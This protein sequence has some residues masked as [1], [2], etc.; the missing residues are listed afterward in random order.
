[1]PVDISQEL[2]R[3]DLRAIGTVFVRSG[4][5]GTVTLWATPETNPERL[6][7]AAQEGGHEPGALILVFAG[8][9]R[10]Y[11]RPEWQRADWLQRYVTELV[12]EI[13]RHGLEGFLGAAWTLAVP[14]LN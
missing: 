5:Q 3:S 13:R 7:R 14:Q 11:L 8:E 9:V 6:R 1:M 12:E 10:S 4:Q 2:E